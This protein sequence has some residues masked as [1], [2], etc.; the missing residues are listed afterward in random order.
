M[1]D[2]GDPS[3]K[4]SSSNPSSSMS[5]L[6]KLGQVASPLRACFLICTNPLGYHGDALTQ[7]HM[8]RGPGTW[9]VF[10]IIIREWVCIYS[11][12]YWIQR[13]V[14]LKP[15]GKVSLLRVF[16]EEDCPFPQIQLDL[17]PTGLQSGPRVLKHSCRLWGSHS[18]VLAFTLTWFYIHS[19]SVPAGSTSVNST[20]IEYPQILVP[21]GILGASQVVSASGKKPACQPRRHK[22]HRFDPQVRNTPGEGSGNL[23]QYSFLG[24]PMDRGA[25]WVTVHRV[26][27]SQTQ[28]SMHAHIYMMMMK[29]INIRFRIQVMSSEAKSY[30]KCTLFVEYYWKY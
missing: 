25:W 28:L 21:M 18:L 7:T 5:L 17:P 23:L 3:I 19:A 2:P 29:M 30:D 12:G 6:C 26:T 13:M 22:R 16:M 24:N 10:I 11:L 14:L 1:L 15:V 8:A 9:S 27:K 20:I 4:R